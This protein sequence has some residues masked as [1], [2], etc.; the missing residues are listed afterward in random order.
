MN[1]MVPYTC[2]LTLDALFHFNRPNGLDNPKGTKGEMQLQAWSIN[3]FIT[4]SALLNV[5]NHEFV[6]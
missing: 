6:S 3:N 2:C 1:K 5:P 4:L